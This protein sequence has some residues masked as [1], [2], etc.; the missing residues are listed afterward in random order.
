MYDGAPCS[1]DALRAMNVNP[2]TGLATDYLNVFNEPIMLLEMVPDAPELIEELVG[3]EA[4]DYVTHFRNS[5]FAAR[6]TII[7]AYESA[8]GREELDALAR[9]L[10]RRLGMLIDQVTSADPDHAAALVG[11]ALPS[12]QQDAASLDR[13]IHG[14]GTAQD[15]VDALF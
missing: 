14:R 12:I 5:H 1:D 9:A 13:V 4:V 3:W 15:A 6:D 2:D 8:P 10:S 7:A 11:Q